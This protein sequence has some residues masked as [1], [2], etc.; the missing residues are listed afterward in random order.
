MNTTAKNSPLEQTIA[1]VERALFAWLELRG[2]GPRD[3]DGS[4]PARPIQSYKPTHDERANQAVAMWNQLA[5][6]FTQA[7]SAFNAEMPA[8]ARRIVQSLDSFVAGV[9]VPVEAFLRS[10][11]DSE[12]VR[13]MSDASGVSMNDIAV[14]L[15]EI[16]LT[17]HA[18]Q[19]QIEYLLRLC[20]PFAPVFK[21]FGVTARTKEP[22]LSCFEWRLM[23]EAGWDPADIADLDGSYDRV[24]NTPGER[25]GA[26]HALVKRV[27]RFD[28]YFR[29][30]LHAAGVPQATAAADSSEVR[31]A[32]LQRD[33]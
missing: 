7:E 29:P 10:A 30:V 11:N 13:R 4:I 20:K 27:E 33:R 14:A 19:A 26:V 25:A 6:Q 32:V 8:S 23:T 22:L 17:I 28:R 1:N 18:L 12:Y 9:R 16:A 5:D 24:R 21:R 15:D 31:Q 3:P 2:V